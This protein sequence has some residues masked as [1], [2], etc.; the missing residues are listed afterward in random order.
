MEP[1]LRRLLLQ[2]DCH[3]SARAVVPGIVGNGQQVVFPYFA[4]D[5]SDTAQQVRALFGPE[6]DVSRHGQ[7][8]KLAPVKITYDASNLTDNEKKVLIL[9]VKAAKY[10]DKIFLTQV[11]K[12]NFRILHELNKKRKKNPDYA[13]LKKYM[14]INFG[15]FDRLAADKPFI[16]LQVKKPKGANFYPGKMH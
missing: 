4:P 16:N 12:K 14:K 2:P 6:P 10:M 1:L 9:L 15:P 7:M 3:L 5:D 8:A 13:I 11:Y